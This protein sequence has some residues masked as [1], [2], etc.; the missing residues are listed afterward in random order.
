MQYPQHSSPPPPSRG[1]FEEKRRF[2]KYVVFTFLLLY[3]I[4][5]FYGLNHYSR[6]VGQDAPS[7]GSSSA[8]EKVK[9]ND[10][11]PK[12]KVDQQ[13]KEKEEKEND[14]SWADRKYYIDTEPDDF[15][16][17]LYIT[18]TE[19]NSQYDA[20]R[21][22]NTKHF[23]NPVCGR[24]RFSTS[25]LPSVSVIV[26]VQNEVSGMISITA[27]SV[28]ART[29]PELLKEVI[30]V[31]DNGLDPSVRGNDEPVDEDEFA[32][33]KTL[34]PKI[35]IHQN[36]D[37]EGCARS[38]LIGARHATGEVLMFV[39]SH[40]EMESS[41][42]LQHLLI[43]ILENPNTMSI[44][45][46]DTISD[47]DANRTYSANGHQYGVV[48]DKFFFTYVANR[49]GDMGIMETAPSRLY[50]ET[51][52]GPGS[53]FAIRRD[54]FWKLG[55]YDEGLYVWGGENTEL[56]LK[57]WTC[58]GRVVMVPC[59]RVGHMYRQ[60]IKETGRWPPK[61]PQVITDALG[62]GH[63][64]KWRV[65]G[66]RADNFSKIT[67]RNNMR[68]M[69]LWIGDHPAR[70]K[71]YQKSFEAD[72]DELPPE[73][74]QY[75]EEMERDPYWLKQKEI[76][77]ANKCKDFEWFDKHVFMK[78]VGRHHPWHPKS[79][80]R[81]Y[82]EVGVNC[83]AHHAKSCFACPQGNGASWCNGD[84]KWEGGQCIIRDSAK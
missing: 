45:A 39:D 7:V 63:E 49:F 64:G 66:A 57:V 31:D 59:S 46:I 43:P 41:T 65:H 82:D 68:V 35:H 20:V 18:D 73:W 37:R 58:G 70:T 71:Y 74:Q 75:V 84:C 25:S 56:A 61:I 42:W 29:P 36:Q 80:Q 19:R 2:N 8:A 51:P 40:V 4:L 81:K 38:R 1:V 6:G 21:T 44:Q 16:E 54:F 33:L 47:V 53:L 76:K 67:T 34:S 23:F 17:K 24:Y 15:Y 26:T 79:I 22:L 52:F 62:L 72:Y 77:G 48:D 60:H 30:V 50:Y 55:G 11:K 28:L 27:Q 10:T 32:K 14:M 3:P 69:N 5:L 78:L 9:P 13:R 12:E 83:G